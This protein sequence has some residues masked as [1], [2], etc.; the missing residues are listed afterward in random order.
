MAKD[1]KDAKKKTGRKLGRGLGGL[2]RTP[3]AIDAPSE[4]AVVDAPATPMEQ[5]ATVPSPSPE[6]PTGDSDLQH[7]PLS[8]ITTNPRQPRQR[9]EDVAL[10]QLADSIRNSGLMQP[11]VVRPSGSGFELVAGERRMRAFQQLKR[12]AIP[13]IVRGLDDREAAEWALVE[14]LQRE[15]LDPLERADGIAKLMTEFQLTQSE[16]GKQ[17]GLDRATIANLLRLRDADEDTRKA[18]EEGLITQGH[19]RA[20]LGCT[21][22]ARRKILLGKCVRGGWSV[23]ETERQ[24]QQVP[25]KTTTSSVPRSSH[26]EDLEERLG[27]HLGTKVRISL[28]RKKGTGKMSLEFYTLDQFEGLLDR[29][30]FQ[31]EG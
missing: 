14:N 8:S 29:L 22:L 19:A 1:A 27:A 2:I 11:I 13:A 5:P 28:G 31:N 24:V 9:F 26:V 15:D 16:A 21:D 20:L 25:G 12:E 30:G 17:L 3:V 7:I 10:I 4:P 23:R 6:A 18:L